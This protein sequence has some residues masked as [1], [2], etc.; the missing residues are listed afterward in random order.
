MNEQEKIIWGLKCDVIKLQTEVNSLR[1]TLFRQG[2]SIASYYKAID[3]VHEA[4]K[5]V[6]HGE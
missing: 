3:G 1:E 4:I 5:G 2:R 6:W